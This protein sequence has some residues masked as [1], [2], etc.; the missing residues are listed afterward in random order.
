MRTHGGNV[1]QGGAPEDWLD[2]SANLRPGDPPEWV[3]SV[4][5]DAISRAAYYPDP[6]MREARASLAEY[7][8]LNEKW[9]LPTAGGIS[10]IALA[11]QLPVAGMMAFAPCFGEYARTAELRGFLLEFLPLID[12]DRR[13]LSPAE[14]LGDRDINS[15]AV[16]LCNPLNPVG[17]AFSRSEIESL[18]ARI[19]ANGGWLV[20]DEAFI[21][22]CPE[23]SSIDLLTEHPRLLIVGSLTKSLGI[24]GVRLGY[25]C[26]RPDVLKMLAEHQTTW[27]LSC[28]A[29]GVLRALPAHTEELRAEAQKNAARRVALRGELERLGV[30]VYPSEANFLLA[31]FKRKV[32]P[33][34]ARLRERGILVRECMDFSG[35]QDGQHL[36]LAVKDEIA[37]ARFI[38]TLEGVLNTDRFDQ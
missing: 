22:C 25:L 27:E 18:L 24:P 33:I 20:L 19:E 11:A 35:I 7:L 23:R 38:E 12:G 29:E 15:R 9:V 3:R 6:A 26:A 1:W 8:G 32:A 30:Y 10:G 34:A 37:N 16:W 4:L 36:R 31:D 5:N 13:I 14:V 17:I 2:F 28:F 21:H